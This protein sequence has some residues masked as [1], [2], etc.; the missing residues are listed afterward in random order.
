MSE[1]TTSVFDSGR[2]YYGYDTFHF[3]VGF[4]RDNR[5]DSGS[6]SEYSDG[7][8]LYKTTKSWFPTFVLIIGKK[9]LKDQ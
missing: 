1:G 9:C 8:I 3:R 4:C 2:V 6:G 7:S 5:C